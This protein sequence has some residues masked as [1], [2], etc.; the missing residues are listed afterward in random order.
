M[1]WIWMTSGSWR[2]TSLLSYAGR[3]SKRTIDGYLQH[4]EYF[5][6]FLESKSLST[7]VT[8]AVTRDSIGNYIEH[9]LTRKNARSGEP[10]SPEY[11]RGQYRSLQQFAKYLVVE[12]IV[13]Q[14][15]VRQDYASGRARTT[16]ARTADRCVEESVSRV[17]RNRFRLA[18]RHGHH[19]AVPGHRMSTRGDR[20]A[21]GVGC[22]LRRKHRYCGWEGSSAADSAVRRQDP[23]SAGRDLRERAKHPKATNDEQALWLGKFGPMTDHGSVNL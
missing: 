15:P 3:T 14:Q 8:I 6:T 7:N 19:P 21:T 18:Q 20:A 2:K 5:A 11:A 17:L 16:G 4:I 13:G 1:T 22:R 23:D 10:L 9:L 12:E